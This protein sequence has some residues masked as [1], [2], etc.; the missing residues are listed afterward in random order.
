MQHQPLNRKSRFDANR[1]DN[2]RFSD[3]RCH[4]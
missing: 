2:D 3:N 4:A 1:D